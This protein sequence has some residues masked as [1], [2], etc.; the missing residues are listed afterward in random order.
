MNLKKLNLKTITLFLFFLF[1]LTD[2]ISS[3]MVSV[4]H[5]TE[6]ETNPY[7]TLGIPLWILFILKV[8]FM[9]AFIFVLIKFYPKLNIYLRYFLVY[10]LVFYVIILPIVSIDN[11]KLFMHS[12]EEVKPIPK[13]QRTQYYVEN[14]GNMKAIE[15][16]PL[17]E[18]L[19]IPLVFSLLFYNFVVFAVWLSFETD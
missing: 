1:T 19:K 2:I 5:G 18:G 13:E 16:L 10:F 7:S 4:K 6:F 8:I 17:K 14:I 3:V 11:F 12:V 9:F 15:K